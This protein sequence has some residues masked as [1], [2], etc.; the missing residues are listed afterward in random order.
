M[1]P[2]G[3][4]KILT[5]TDWLYIAKNYETA[6]GAVIAESLGI[7]VARVNSIVSVLRR[8]GV[9]IKS[10]R[11]TRE[12]YADFVKENLKKPNPQNTA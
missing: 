11:Q 1:K 5:K 9:A 2:K 10:R 4:E 12:N 6:G 8:K 7:S 3:D